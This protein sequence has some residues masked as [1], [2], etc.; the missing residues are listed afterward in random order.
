MVLLL[1]H[2]MASNKLVST[3]LTL[4][5][6]RGEG[7]EDSEPMAKGSDFSH[8]VTVWFPYEFTAA[9]AENVSMKQPNLMKYTTKNQLLK[10][11]K[12]IK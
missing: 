10:S 7:G 11:E 9:I 12:Q 1:Y 4:T 3:R 8:K 5:L 2:F 6:S